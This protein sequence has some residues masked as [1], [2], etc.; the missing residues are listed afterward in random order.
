[1]T[2]CCILVSPGGRLELSRRQLPQNVFRACN[3][4]LSYEGT[5]RDNNQERT[6]FELRALSSISASLPVLGCAPGKHGIHLT[7][8]RQGASQSRRRCGR[9]C[10]CA[11]YFKILRSRNRRAPYRHGG[12]IR[13]F[14]EYFFSLAN[15]TVLLL[16]PQAASKSPRGTVWI[17]PQLA[18]RDVVGEKPGRILQ[19]SNLPKKHELCR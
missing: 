16:L 18:A 17:V 10:F 4:L 8:P 7:D 2:P 13:S 12:S 3:S 9:T 15:C 1:M 11:T 5:A 14:L 19:S 6:P